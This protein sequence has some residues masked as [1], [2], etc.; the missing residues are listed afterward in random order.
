MPFSPFVFQ[1][2]T[3][4]LPIHQVCVTTG[5]VHTLSLSFHVLSATE[6]QAGTII[7]PGPEAG[8]VH[9]SQTIAAPPYWEEVVFGEKSDC[10]CAGQGTQF[11]LPSHWF[12]KV[13]HKFLEELTS[14]VL[15]TVATGTE[16]GQRLSRFCP[17]SLVGDDYAFFICSASFYMV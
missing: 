12:W 13:A 15:T 1:M 9:A 7:T 5:I 2:L 3:I 10:W 14:T 8:G 4:L 16:V 17:K 6:N 11:F